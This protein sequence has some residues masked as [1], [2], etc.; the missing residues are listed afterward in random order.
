MP[1]QSDRLRLPFLVAGQAQKENTHNEALALVDMLA[2]P[3]VQAVAPAS[4]PASPAVGQCWIVGTGA[5]GAWAGQDNALACWASGGWLFSTAFEGM[6]VWN[7]ATGSFARRGA[8]AWVIGVLA[9]ASVNVAGNQVVTARQAAIASPS[10]GTVID[11]EG[12]L[13]I[14]AILSAL[15]THGLI[16]P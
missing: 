1:D 11:V 16:A 4:I 13:A 9:G 8:A 5:T 6:T 15:R 7:I 2:Q 12:R 3:V 10:G 14:T